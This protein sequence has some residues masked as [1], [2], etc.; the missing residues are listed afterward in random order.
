MVTLKNNTIPASIH[1][2][3]VKIRKPTCPRCNNRLQ[4]NFADMEPKCV[5]CGFVDYTFIPKI[6]VGKSILQT[7]TEYYIRYNGTYDY[8]KE[9]T[10]HVK[11]IRIGNA[12]GSGRLENKPNCPFCEGSMESLSLSG[13]RKDKIEAR[14]KCASDHRISLFMGSERSEMSW[15]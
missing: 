6:S 2:D 13:K 8:L 10:V 1:H 12:N 5:A 4:Q 7:A 11:T 3:P 15:R 14:F 9:T